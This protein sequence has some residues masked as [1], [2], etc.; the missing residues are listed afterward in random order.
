MELTKFV[1]KFL[2]DCSIRYDDF[3]KNKYD[4]M[5]QNL[6][7]I[8][9]VE[10]NFQEALQNF[11]E[12]ICKKQRENCM[13]DIWYNNLENYIPDNL[14]SIFFDVLEN[15]IDSAEQPKIDEL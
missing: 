15:N 12:L 1:E 9:F 13:N 8:D 3:V 5:L 10:L 7:I 4:G 6:A 11:T 14:S 2:P